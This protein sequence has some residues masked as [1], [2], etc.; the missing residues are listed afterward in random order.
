M[1]RLNYF[2]TISVFAFIILWLGGFMAFHQMIRSYPINLTTKTD[3]IVALTGG[4]NRISEAVKLYNQGMGDTLIISG[5]ARNVKLQQIEKENKT[6]VN[7][8]P[9][10][11]ILGDEARNTIENAIEVNEAIKRHGIRSVRLVTSYYHMPRSEQELLAQNHD[12]LIVRHP[13]Y[14]KNVS[15]KWWKKWNSFYLIAGEYNKF[16]FV[17]IKNLLIKIAQRQ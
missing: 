9:N 7:H 10:H 12:L 14:S 8:M 6:S 15:A 17:Y 5:V 3:A 2:A 11:V 1:R 16:V 13:V 4:R